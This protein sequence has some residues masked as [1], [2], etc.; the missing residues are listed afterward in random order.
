MSDNSIKRFENF[1]PKRKYG[2]MLNQ[3][4]IEGKTGK[5]FFSRSKDFEMIVYF[6]PLKEI[7]LD[8]TIEGTTLLDKRLNIDFKIGDNI[9]KLKDWVSKNNHTITHEI[10]RFEF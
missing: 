9:D 4:F 3:I 8:I 10:N 1:M 7:I 6:T 2:K 5:T